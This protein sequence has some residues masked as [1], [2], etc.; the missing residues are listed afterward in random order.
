[1]PNELE[2]RATGGDAWRASNLAKR[3]FDKRK[4]GASIARII[5]ALLV[6]DPLSEWDR[7]TQLL[8]LFKPRVLTYES[9]KSGPRIEEISAELG[10]EGRRAS[11]HIQPIHL[12][13]LSVPGLASKVVLHRTSSLD[14]L[15]FSE[16]VNHSIFSKQLFYGFK[17]L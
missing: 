5:E 7:H 15:V 10:T 4:A 9:T 2:Y 11:S 12:P 17:S 16:A 6:G 1:M 8:P 14:W 3:A 13:H